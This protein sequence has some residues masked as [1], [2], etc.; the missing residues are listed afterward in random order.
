MDALKS[1]S[2]LAYSSFVAGPALPPEAPLAMPEQSLWDSRSATCGR[3]P[4]SPFAMPARRAI[5]F[6]ATA[7]LTAFA[8]YQMYQVLAVSTL[9]TLGSIILALFTILFAWIALSFVSALIGF[10]LSLATTDQTLGLDPSL[11]LP[12]LNSR[13]A[14]LIPTYNERPG[15]IV[16]RL[17][18]IFE[19]IAE[20]GQVSN[21]DFFILSDSTDPT[22]WIQEEAQYLSLLD[23]VQTNQIYYRHRQNNIA[24]KSGNIAEWVARFGGRYESMLILDADSLMTGDTIIRITAALERRPDVG[25]IQTLPLIV[26]G[27]SL[28]ARLQQFAGRL[29][30]PMIA[31]GIAWWHGSESNYWG[32]NAAIR[33]KAFAEHCG[34]PSLTGRKP[35][36]GH[37]LSHDFVE[38]ALMRREGWAI[39]FAPGL[40]GSYEETPPSLTEYA[41]RDRRWCQG[42]LQHLKVLSAHRMHW[43]SRLHLVTGIGAYLTAPLWFIFLLIGILISLQAQFIRPE[44]FP[45]GFSLFPQWAVEDPIRAAW[46]FVGTM[47][48]LLAPKVLALIVA[49]VH[50]VDRQGFGGSL[51]A[52]AGVTIEILVSGLIAPTMML[53]QSRAVADIFLG[54]DSG[55][56]VQRRE[57]GAAPLAESIRR[58]GKFTLM[59]LAL[60]G[61][62]YIVSP[63]LFIWMTPVIV[64]LSLIIPLV[65]F[66]ARAD[67]GAA[68]CRLGLLL[69]PEERDVPKIVAR[70][71]ELSAAL[72]DKI[73][74]ADLLRQS[75]RLRQI[76]SLMILPRKPRSPGQIDADLTIAKAKIEDASTVEEALSFFSIDEMRAAFS[77][78]ET[79]ERLSALK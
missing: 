75:P 53:I 76:H 19:S 70:A 24:R 12:C 73:P 71:N 25:L 68:F 31:R 50:R 57:N 40:R 28:F 44:Y 20:C 42:N 43:I 32:H 69:T 1:P 41:A 3:V 48:I 11:A 51:R 13:H 67:V 29:Y 5:I 23:R 2:T 74:I 45:K 4:S 59:G 47:G 36:G 61:A 34:L 18:S 38:A 16:A 58:Y 54:R 8:T 35:F 64:G 65:S 7:G 56:Q 26:N 30:G 66:T 17:Q 49:L 15:H 55:W 77:D 9:T 6:T 21:F 72:N 14:L 79:F 62:A 60:G 33:V 46:V 22:V 52:L 27:Q 78:R 10:W 39:V 37:I 63:S